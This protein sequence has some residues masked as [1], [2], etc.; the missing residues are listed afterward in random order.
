MK[1]KSHL[2]TMLW[3]FILGYTAIVPAVAQKPT[4]AG[5]H[6]L[7][8]AGTVRSETVIVEHEKH[9]ERIIAHRDAFRPKQIFYDVVKEYWNE[10]YWK[11]YN[12]IEPTESLENAVK[13]LRRHL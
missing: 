11:D 13:K 9:P 6:E 1:S 12:I 3:L 7:T 5:K 10:D 4:D 8:V 2:I